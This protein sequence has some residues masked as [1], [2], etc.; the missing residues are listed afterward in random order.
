MI[1]SCLQ[2]W[3]SGCNIQSIAKSLNPSIKQPFT[4]SNQSIQYF[5]SPNQPI[6]QSSNQTRSINHIIA[7][8][9]ENQP[10][11]ATIDLLT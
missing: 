3:V 4:Q 6:N 1:G 5:K 8:W 7:Q 2:D 11:K 9:A 10:A